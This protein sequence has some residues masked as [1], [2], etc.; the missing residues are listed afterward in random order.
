M[1]DPV[2]L[3]DIPDTKNVSNYVSANTTI[4][5]LVDKISFVYNY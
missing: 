4:D 1:N 5:K 3:N 2:K